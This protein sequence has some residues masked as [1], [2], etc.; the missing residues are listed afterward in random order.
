[1]LK[2]FTKMQPKHGDGILHCGHIE[3]GKHHFTL[4]RP[5]MT[6]RRPDGTMGEAEWIV[7]CEACFSKRGNT[8]NFIIRGDG[9]WKGDEPS[10]VVNAGMN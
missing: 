10:V 9:T 2:N 5:A 3:E 4:S 7:E 6:F 1:M 8:R